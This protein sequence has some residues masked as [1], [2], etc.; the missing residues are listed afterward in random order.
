MVADAHAYS[1][2]LVLV[3]QLVFLGGYPAQPNKM[4]YLY[5]C[6]RCSLIPKT[7]P[8]RWVGAN[9]IYRAVPDVSSERLGAP[10]RTNRVQEIINVYI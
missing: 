4:G 7:S 5:L 10:K 3:A 6:Q 2:L 9:S 8:I 1:R